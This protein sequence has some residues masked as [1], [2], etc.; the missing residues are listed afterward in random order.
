MKAL[1]VGVVVLSVTLIVCGCNSPQGN[2]ETTTPTET[3]TELLTEKASENV[4]E[5]VNQITTESKS[6]E[7]ES[8]TIEY[9]DGFEVADYDKFNSYASDNGLDGTYIYVEGYVLNQTQIDD[10]IG[11]VVEQ[12]D[13]N[14]WNI[15]YN[16]DSI[17]EELKGKRIKAYV[18]Y[19]GFSDVFN[20]PSAVAIADTEDMLD[21]VRIEVEDNNSWITAFSWI[22]YAQ[23][24]M[25]ETQEVETTTQEVQTELTTEAKITMGK[26]NALQTAKDYLKFS[27]FSYEGLYSQLQYEGYTDDES[28]YGVDNCGANWNEQALGT[29]K[30]Y[31]KFSSFS[32]EGLCNQLIY[33]KYTDSQAR[34]G[35]DNCGA[36][37]NEQARKTAESYLKYSTF[38]RQSLY[39]QLLYEGFT[40]EQAE[41][42][43]TAVGY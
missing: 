20:L 27:N 6:I 28:K 12:D 33:E 4:P 23:K 21:K 18:R 24:K 11:A 37:W 17:I 31:L 41:Y 25:Q 22:E 35:V 39:E 30:D 10:T 5:T 40:E 3:T 7:A 9:I 26:R 29:A 42:G 1:K 43:V 2:A 19:M 32:Y 14:R 13:G 36:D 15:G 34:Y 38:S 8:K 16:S